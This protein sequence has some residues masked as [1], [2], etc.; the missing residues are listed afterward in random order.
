MN[1]GLAKLRRG[2]QAYKD[3]KAVSDRIG[4]RNDSDPLIIAPGSLAGGQI[5]VANDA[6]HMTIDTGAADSAA[7]AFAPFNPGV[8]R[9]DLAAAFG[10]AA[11]S[12]EG[13]HQ[14]DYVT[15]GRGYP[16]DRRSERATEIRAYRTEIGVPKGLGYS[17]DT[18]APGA[19]S[20]ALESRVQENADASTNMFCKQ[21]G[22]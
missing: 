17:T 5:A 4:K 15:P 9:S 16:T 8:S 1:S 22:C 10:G 2:S 3:L 21:N 13:Q 18:Y 19:T 6:F 14:L 7:A 20:S 12:H 11:V